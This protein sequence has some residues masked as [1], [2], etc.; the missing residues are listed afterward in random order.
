MFVRKLE[1]KRR[2]I[3]D[4]AEVESTEES[5]QDHGH[6]STEETSASSDRW[7]AAT[8]QREKATR[9]LTELV[10]FARVEAAAALET[11]IDTHLKVCEMVDREGVL[12]E[13][14]REVRAGTRE[15]VSAQGFV[16]PT[17]RLASMARFGY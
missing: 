5:Y 4:A 11:W 15:I 3:D 6:P 16:Y 7:I 2:E 8:A 1:L 17:Y 13:Q 12:A 10:R 9:E 14:W